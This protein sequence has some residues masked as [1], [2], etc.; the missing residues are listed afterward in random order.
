MTSENFIKLVEGWVE[1]ANG[2]HY[3]KAKSERGYGAR[4]EAR[5]HFIMVNS[6]SLPLKGVR[7]LDFSPSSSRT[8][9]RTSLA[10][11]LGAGRTIWIRP[12]HRCSC[13]SLLALKR[14]KKSPL[15]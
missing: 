2:L 13:V 6:S 4:P 9:L 7:I 12:A 15:I 1:L 10:C 3:R 8:V 14:K 11:S 5:R